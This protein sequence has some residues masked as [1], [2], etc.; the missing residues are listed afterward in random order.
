MKQI[1]RYTLISFITVIFLLVSIY[2]P[3]PA[4]QISFLNVGQGDAT[5]IRVHNINILVDGGPDNSL[6]SELANHLPWWE[7]EIDY[8]VVTHYHEDHL[9]GL[10]ELMNKYKIKNILVSAHQ[11]ESDFYYQLWHESLAK[12]HLQPTIVQAGEQFVI[13]A[14]TKWQILSADTNHEDYNE[15]SVVMRFSYRDVDLLLM[16][17][18]PQVGE[19]RILANHFFLESE[20]IKVGHH[21]SKYSSGPEF[22]AAVKP[23]YCLIE[24]GQNN[25]FGHPHAETINRLRQIGCQILDTQEKGSITITSNGQ[26]VAVDK[27]LTP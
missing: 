27:S 1:S 21:G 5:L 15:N 23:S 25:K 12:H 2:W 24:S 14:D 13:D 22:L 8:V 19:Q 6:L 4:L 26:V 3:R 11:P 16:G 7:R 20:I 18:L 10:I 17:D 9:L